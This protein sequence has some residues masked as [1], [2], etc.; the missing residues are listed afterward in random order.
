MNISSKASDWKYY[1]NEINYTAQAAGQRFTK[2]T[3]P[4]SG[5]YVVIFMTSLWIAGSFGTPIKFHVN[6]TVINETH[7]AWNISLWKNV[8]VT[9]VHFSELIFNSD[10]VASSEK[11]FLVFA[12]WF[13]G[14]SGGFYSFPIA[15]QD[16]FIMGVT[17][18]EQT[19]ARCG[20]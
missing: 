12:R 14:A 8:H 3:A 17:A 7:Y 4:Y 2:F 20:F 13:N 15:F 9:N 1:V 5:N 18:F 6:T 11:Y 10:D 19:D 16:N